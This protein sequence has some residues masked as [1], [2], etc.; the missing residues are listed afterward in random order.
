MEY[1]QLFISEFWKSFSYW[2]KD[3]AFLI[4][5]RKQTINVL[6]DGGLKRRNKKNEI[7]SQF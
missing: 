7:Q 5:F 2:T 3:C 1:I 6:E 4:K